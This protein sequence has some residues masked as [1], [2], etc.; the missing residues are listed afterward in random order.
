MKNS[1]CNKCGF[2]TNNEELVTSHTCTILPKINCAECPYSTRLVNKMD[3]HMSFEHMA[4]LK[5][6]QCNYE[7]IHN[8]KHRY[9]AK[10]SMSTHMDLH[11]IGTF[12]CFECGETFKVK[13][14]L[15]Y[16]IKSKHLQYICQDCNTEDSSPYRLNQHIKKTHS[17]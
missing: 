6:S 11:N 2:S 1:I 15:T 17:L 14:K 10:Y 9:A 4:P 13:R 7:T 3:M 12:D 8:P 5:C 16:H